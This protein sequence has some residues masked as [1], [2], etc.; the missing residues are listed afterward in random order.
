MK[1]L[2]I[3]NTTSSQVDW[4]V[5]E[6]VTSKFIE[7]ACSKENELI[8][9]LLRNKVTPVIKGEITKGKVKWRGLRLASFS[10][11]GSVT[12]YLMQRE[13]Q[14]GVISIISGYEYSIGGAVNN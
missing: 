5:L 3:P 13:K 9:Y 2:I 7:N 10:N 11:G 12:K 8:E 14:I 1:K 4:N 6:E